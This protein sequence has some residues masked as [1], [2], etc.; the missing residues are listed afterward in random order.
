MKKLIIFITAISIFTFCKKKNETPALVPAP[1]NATPVNTSL[2]N[3]LGN[4]TNSLH[5]VMQAEKL[6]IPSFSITS[7]ESRAAF[8]SITQPYSFYYML[9]GI[10]ATTGV[11]SGVLK[12]NSTTLIYD[13]TTP[14]EMNRYKD[15]VSSRNYSVGAT[16]D[17]T[18]NNNLSSFSVNIARGFPSITNPN[19]LPN[20]ISK[21]SGFTIN[22]GATNYSNTDSI[23]VFLA[24]G[25]G[26]TSYPY[27]HI[28]GN[29]TSVTYSSAEL[30]NVGTGSGQIIVYGINYSNM[31]VNSKN[32]LYIMQYDVINFI[33]INP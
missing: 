21:A 29:A 25:T 11:N 7:Y 16:W 28:S 19:Y 32:Y 30:N 23:I 13:L 15:T 3:G 17:L 20:T 14:N 8:N 26:T 27:K 31:T 4:Y 9:G 2:Q 22:F 1:V 6:T 18:A 33:T 5:G 10:F 24:G 12:L